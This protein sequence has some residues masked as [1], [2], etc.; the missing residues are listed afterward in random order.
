MGYPELKPFFHDEKLESNNLSYSIAIS[1]TVMLH[2][3]SDVLK[4]FTLK[5]MTKWVSSCVVFRKS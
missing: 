3:G 4:T 2:T 5:I 1:V